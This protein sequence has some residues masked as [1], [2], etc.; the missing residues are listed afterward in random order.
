M[1]ENF[2]VGWK[3]YRDYEKENLL[4]LLVVVMLG[5]VITVLIKTYFIFKRK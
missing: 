4:R 5:A 2:K 3:D 1:G